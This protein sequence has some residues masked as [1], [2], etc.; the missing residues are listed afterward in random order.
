MAD[1]DN[2]DVAGTVDKMAQIK[3]RRMDELS[4]SGWPVRASLR[5]AWLCS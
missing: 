4:E 3:R 5:M 2:M 1:E